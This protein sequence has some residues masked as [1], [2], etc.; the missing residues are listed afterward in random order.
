MRALD[1]RARAVGLT[2]RGA[3]EGP[4]DGAP[5]GT[6]T[7]VLL[8]PDEPAFWAQFTASDEYGDG[9]PHPLDRWSRRVICDLASAE[10]GTALFPFDGPPYAPFVSWALSSGRAWISPVG[11]MVHDDAGL[12]ISYRGAIAL[13]RALPV[14]APGRQ[15]CTGCAAPCTTACP[16]GALSADHP[17]DV[18]RC[19]DYITTDAGETCRSR[20]CLARR[21]CPTDTGFH[22]RAGQSAF[23]MDAFVKAHRP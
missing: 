17:Y 22:R 21:A 18:A 5:P 10:G 2:I 4:M 15:P 8:G 16:V 3:L 19:L 12:F 1:D 11:P 20:G 13:P 14:P 9:A 23:H 7:L 6:R